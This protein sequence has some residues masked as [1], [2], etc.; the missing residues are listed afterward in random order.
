[1]AESQRQITIPLPMYGV[2]AFQIVTLLMAQLVNKGI[3]TNQE[4]AALFNNASAGLSPVNDPGVQA[5]KQ[6]LW[7]LSATTQGS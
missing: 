3:L 4:R 2:A 7:Q 6:L 1:M 5:M